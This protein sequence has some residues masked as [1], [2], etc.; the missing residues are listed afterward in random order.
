MKLAL[1]QPLNTICPQ[2]GEDWL[3]S[4]RVARLEYCPRCGSPVVGLAFD[5]LRAQVIGNGAALRVNSGAK[6]IVRS[7]VLVI[8]LICFLTGLS[9]IYGGWFS[10]AGELDAVQ[11]WV[12][13]AGGPL[14]VLYGLVSAWLPFRRPVGA[15]ILPFTSRLR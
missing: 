15:V 5:P 13:R 10:G 4:G 6:L 12:S 8:G 1:I 7:G 3:A 11:L 2:C 9:M 14:L